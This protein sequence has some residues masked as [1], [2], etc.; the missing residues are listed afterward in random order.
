LITQELVEKAGK[1]QPNRYILVYEGDKLVE[2]TD[3]D[4]GYLWIKLSDGSWVWIA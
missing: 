4:S 1:E 2:F 3:K